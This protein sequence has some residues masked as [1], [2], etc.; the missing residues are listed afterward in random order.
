MADYNELAKYS[1]LPGYR[2]QSTEDLDYV[3]CASAF[4]ATANLPQWQSGQPPGHLRQ[5]WLEK[6]WAHLQFTGELLQWKES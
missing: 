4:L 3:E 5:H 2:T 1:K 6:C